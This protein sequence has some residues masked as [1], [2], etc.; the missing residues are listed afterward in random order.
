MRLLYGLLQET[1][2]ALFRL[3]NVAPALLIITMIAVGR[4]GARRPVLDISNAAML[5]WLRARQ[6]FLRP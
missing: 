1:N 3:S 5:K 2:E 6:P 4:N